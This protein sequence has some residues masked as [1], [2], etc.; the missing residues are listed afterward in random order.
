VVLDEDGFE[1]IARDAFKP[2][3]R[4]GIRLA[5][6]GFLGNWPREEGPI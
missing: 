5:R 4:A 1:L 2:L 6:G 3:C